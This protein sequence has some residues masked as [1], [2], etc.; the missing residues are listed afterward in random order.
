MRQPSRGFNNPK[1]AT[2]WEEYKVR[3]EKAAKRSHSTMGTIENLRPT[4]QPPWPAPEDRQCQAV[5]K[6]L[7]RRCK[8]WAVRGASRCVK[9]GGLREVPDH[10]SNGR[11]WR[12]GEIEVHDRKHQAAKWLRETQENKKAGTEMR[13]LLR[14]RRIP[15]HAVNVKAGI[16]AQRQD[17]NG[18]A[19][20]RFL[21]ANL[22]KEAIKQGVSG[23]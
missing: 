17:D 13:Q 23:E 15:A 10:P 3:A 20:R 22:P 1:A 11:A 18:R 9:H 6:T 12:S 14:E 19:W 8:S 16:E 7:G 2:S 21:A 4:A 5:T